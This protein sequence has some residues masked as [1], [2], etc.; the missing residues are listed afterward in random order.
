MMNKSLSIFVLLLF[1]FQQCSSFNIPNFEGKMEQAGES[2]EN[3]KRNADPLPPISLQ[4]YLKQRLAEIQKSAPA[5][6]SAAAAAPSISY[7]YAGPQQQ[8]HQP[9]KPQFPGLP[10][11]PQLPTNFNPLGIQSAP[12]D[13]LKKSVMDLVKAS[14]MAVNQP[15]T[16]PPSPP[17]QMQQQPPQ[18]LNSHVIQIQPP[19]EGPKPQSAADIKAFIKDLLAGSSRN[20]LNNDDGSSGQSS[21]H[22]NIP[23]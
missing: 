3:V 15:V 9:Q 11:I 17:Q 22:S 18:I 5:A 12:T 21:D 6:K 16:Q 1:V 10:S 2:S 20:K 19:A 14:L 7:Q 4:D 23:G 13:P 8:Q